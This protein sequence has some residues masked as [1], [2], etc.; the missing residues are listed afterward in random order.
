[1]TKGAEFVMVTRREILQGAAALALLARLDPPAAL[2][3]APAKKQND[4]YIPETDPRVLKKLAQWSDWKFGLILHWGTYS[5]LG[6]VRSEEHT[7]ELQSPVHLV[8]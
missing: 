7:S 5:Q 3:A 6:I 8:C 2:A 1:M 4:G